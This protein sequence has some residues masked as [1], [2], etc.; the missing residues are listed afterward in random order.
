MTPEEK[1]YTLMALAEDL[2]AHA[3]TLQSR[4]KAELEGLPK[5]V[6]D[7]GYEVR[8]H[9]T[10]WIGIGIAIVLAAG[11]AV[12]AGVSVYIRHDVGD[13]RDE[14]RTLRAKIA[15]MKQTAADLAGKTWGLT[16]V[17]ADD[18]GIVLP[19]GVEVVRSGKN[20]DDQVF[21]VISS[22][23]KAGRH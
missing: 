15:E 2:Q 12:G 16:L 6:R 8:A 14:A 10:R 9:A 21:I 22:P 7:A 18:R 3:Q 19:K 4:A 20:Q 13:L 5:I 17:E 11:V 1:L 23:K